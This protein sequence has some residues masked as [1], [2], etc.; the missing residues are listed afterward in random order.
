MQ[1]YDQNWGLKLDPPLAIH[2]LF[3][4]LRFCHSKINSKV[5]AEC[6]TLLILNSN[7]LSFLEGVGF[8]DSIPLSLSLQNAWEKSVTFSPL[9]LAHL[10]S[11]HTAVVHSPVKWVAQHNRSRR[12]AVK[13][14]IAKVLMTII[15][16]LC[17]LFWVGYAWKLQIHLQTIP[18]GDGGI[19]EIQEDSLI[20]KRGLQA[21]PFLHIALNNTWPSSQC[22]PGQKSAGSHPRALGVPPALLQVREAQ[23]A[24]W[25]LFT[26]PRANSIVSIAP[27]PFGSHLQNRCQYFDKPV[28][29]GAAWERGQGAPWAGGRCVEGQCHPPGRAR[30]APRRAP[31]ACLPCPLRPGNSS[32]SSA[33][34][35]ADF[36]PNQGH[37]LEKK[38][39]LLWNTKYSARN[40]VRNAA[41]DRTNDCVW[42]WKVKHVLETCLECVLSVC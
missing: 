21:W 36:I 5:K 29:E 13:Y 1:S 32:E 10:L 30:T 34:T 22:Y 37:G 39:T 31:R 4:F 27:K 6:P 23:R 16:K 41:F 8:L 28:T 40:A 24:G 18:H 14:V 17:N 9:S 15:F 3:L 7:S 12:P 19:T 25:G 33:P 35:A 2:S 38:R 42:L 11:L 26:H 20:Q